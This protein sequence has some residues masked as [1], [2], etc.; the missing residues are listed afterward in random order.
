VYVIKPVRSQNRY[1]SIEELNLREGAEKVC[2][3]VV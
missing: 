3:Y 1:K 2:D